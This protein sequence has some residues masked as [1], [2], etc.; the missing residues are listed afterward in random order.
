MSES[1]HRL[2]ELA[3]AE[4]D[5]MKIGE[6]EDQLVT[7]QVEKRDLQSKFEKEQEENK[8]LR[9]TLALRTDCE[10]ELERVRSETH[11]GVEEL[12]VKL[13]AAEAEILLMESTNKELLASL[14]TTRGQLG[15]MLRERNEKIKEVEQLEEALEKME[16]R[17]KRSWSDDLHCDFELN[18]YSTNMKLMLE[19]L[20]DQTS[21]WEKE[22][23]MLKKHYEETEKKL[24]KE[25]AKLK[26]QKEDIVNHSR[27]SEKMYQ[28]RL[29]QVFVELAML[30]D[31]KKSAGSKEDLR[32]QSNQEVNQKLQTALEAIDEMEDENVT[33][34]EKLDEATARISHLDAEISVLRPKLAGRETL[35]EDARKNAEHMALLVKDVIALQD[36]R[37][38][39]KHELSEIMEKQTQ[40]TITFSNEKAKFCHD[41]ERMEEHW[42]NEVGKLKEQNEVMERMLFAATK[43]S[44]D[45]KELFEEEIKEHNQKIEEL[46]CLL[47]VQATMSDRKSEQFK[48]EIAELKDQLEQAKTVQETAVRQWDDECAD[49]EDEINTLLEKR[50][51]ETKKMRTMTRK[52]VWLIKSI[53]KLAEQRRA[54]IDS[55]Q[56]EIQK[57]T[58]L[59]ELQRLE[60][61]ECLS[62]LKEEMNAW[63]E[64]SAVRQELEVEVADLKN[65]NTALENRVVRML[66][67]SKSEREDYL[68]NME[69]LRSDSDFDLSRAEANLNTAKKEKEELSMQ[70]QTLKEV[71]EEKERTLA[72][73]KVESSKLLEATLKSLTTEMD[74]IRTVMNME[75]DR[76]LDEK[77]LLTN[78]L[79]AKNEIIQTHEIDRKTLIEAIAK[80]SQMEK[81]AQSSYEQHEYECSM[82]RA[83]VRQLKTDNKM[84]KENMGVEVLED[85]S[86]DDS[87]C[88]DDSDCSDESDSEE[89]GYDMPKPEEVEKKVSN[90]WE[91]V[92]EDEDECK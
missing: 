46:E 1:L 61:N 86:S 43:D 88:S 59:C 15:K 19:E 52:N 79:A 23:V 14:N 48:G 87:S 9:L 80:I 72:V 44:M 62:N 40:Q 33:L 69:I 27:N 49:L 7:C 16:N 29:D 6:L 25:N 70:I 35:L 89:D 68:R 71:I 91:M 55:K 22:K 51:T 41:M 76:I 81:E 84:L 65:H 28:E 50:S 38:T 82:W 58:K 45:K 73:Q 57:L 56:V 60:N 3:Q 18:T 10:H 32:T 8:A 36:E 85:Q 54:E 78:H 20:N 31:G 74:N 34:R 37:S 42:S 17:Q 75:K 53:R 77:A 47:K 90:E 21:K 13:A 2:M 39:L 66:A 30:Q 4:T 67:R 5:R 92:H 24:T 12:E 64:D 26:A 63:K 11:P 83:E